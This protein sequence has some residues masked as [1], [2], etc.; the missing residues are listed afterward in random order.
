MFIGK[1]LGVRNIIN[2]EK[3]EI[4]QTQNVPQQ[5]NIIQEDKNVS[6]E[7]N[8]FN[9]EH[10]QPEPEKVEGGKKKQVR[11]KKWP[12]C[13]ADMCDFAHPTETVIILININ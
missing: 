1:K 7:V 10:K 13:K 9:N 3:S 6:V 2:K 5:D 11:C 8:N 4:E 12:Q